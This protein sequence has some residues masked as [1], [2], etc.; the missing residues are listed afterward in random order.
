MSEATRKPTHWGLVLLLAALTVAGPLGI[1]LCLPALPSIARDLHATTGQAQ[2]A[3]S[4]FLLGMGI[5]QLFYG[6]AADRLG[7][8]G[9]LL[10]GT[11]IFVIASFACLFVTTAPMLSGAR[12]VQALGACAGGVISRAIVRDNFGHTDTARMLSLM[13]LI[14]GFAPILAPL[15]GGVLLN[16]GGWRASFVFMG[17]FGLAITLAAALRLKESRSEET[18]AHSRTENAFQAYLALLREPQLMGYALAGALNGAALFTYIACSPDLMI[19]S[20]HMSPTL[21]GWVFVV[22]GLGLLVSNQANRMLLRR[23]EPDRILKTASS[24]AV[25]F[26]VLLLAAAITGFGERWSVLP[27]LFALQAS[28]GFMQGNTM[29]G[30]LSIDPRRAGSTSAVMGFASFASGGVGSAVA[31][32]FHDGTAR[33]MAVVTLVVLVGSAMSLRLLALRRRPA[34]PVIA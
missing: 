5:G 24:A 28:Y 33:P 1:A 2:S 10:V 11:V 12:F 8:R 21:F 31:G 15:I 25:F 4:T 13:A 26:A 34:V 9:P 3:V 7:R 32:M 20:Y 30:A 22:N 27:L 6:P 29:A 14:T 23:L 19:N 16:L 18:I 17:L